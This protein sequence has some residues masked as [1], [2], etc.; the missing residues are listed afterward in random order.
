MS[1]LR[2][3]VT[4]SEETAAAHLKEFWT[5][6]P[7][8]KPS[9]CWYPSAGKCFRDLMVWKQYPQLQTQKPPDL[10]V[11]TDYLS[12][13][14]PLELGVLHE[15]D[16]TQVSL[17]RVSKLSVNGNVDYEVSGDF[18]VF[19]DQA[20]PT[21]SALLIDVEVASDTCGKIRQ[22]VLYFQFENLNW[23]EEFVLKRGLR[24]SHLFKIREGCGFGGN[25]KSVSVVY[26]FLGRM[27]CRTLVADPEVHFDWQLFHD[28]CDRYRG[29]TNVAFHLSNLGRLDTLSGFEVRAFSI[30][31]GRGPCSETVVKE[32]LE[33]ITRGSEWEPS[34]DQ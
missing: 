34:S 33:T 26:G 13:A 25:R 28:Y 15:D 11:H 6:R 7:G 9:C 16:H 17:R 14:L 31:S 24:I 2:K 32:A 1:P 8:D 22:S 20:S 30:E 10:F 18:V 27:G 4:A 29:P 21:P 3:L 12:R 19:A 23:F 5:R